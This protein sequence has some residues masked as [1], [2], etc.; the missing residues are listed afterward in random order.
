MFFVKKLKQLFRNPYF[1]TTVIVIAVFV[2]L[3]ISK[4]IYPFGE[5]SLIWGD[6]HDQV[7]AFYYHFYDCFHGNSSLLINFSTSGGI[8]F[9]G[10]LAYYLLSPV[11]FVLLLFPRENLYQAISI[12]ISIKV[13]LSALTCLYFIKTYF[14]DTPH[15]ISVLLA[16]LYAFCG[17][18]L[19]LYQITA[20]TDIV[21]LF[22]LLLIGLKKLLDLEK[23]IWY[24]VILTLCLIFCFYLSGIMLFF[25]FFSSLFYLYFFKKK[26][27]YKKAIIN[28]GIGTIIALLLSA[29]IVIPTLQE[30]MVSSRVG[31]NLTTLLNSQ[32]GPLN[33]KLC[34][35]ITAGLSI[36]GTVLLFMKGSK[37][38]KHHPV[39]GFLAC[40]ILLLLIPVFIEPVNKMWH[41]GSYAFFPLRIGFILLFI[42]L[43][44][45]LYY[46]SHIARYKEF[47][48][49]NQK[50]ALLITFVTVIILILIT[51]LNYSYLQHKIFGISLG[52]NMQVAITLLS[53][54]GLTGGSIFAILFL[55]QYNY[56]KKTFAFISVIALTNLMCS[57]YLYF[58]IDFAQKNL[59]GVYQD[60]QLM[61]QSYQENDY[62][63]VKNIY[64][65]LVMNNG[66]VTRYH[67]LDHFTSLTD[68]SN[69]ET[70]KKMGY[71]SYWVKTYSIGGSLF[72]DAVLSNQ[73]L[74]SQDSYYNPYYQYVQDY[75]DIRFY[76]NNLTIPFGYIIDHDQEIMSLANS[77][78]VQNAIYQGITGQNESIFT[79]PDESWSK[80]NLSITPDKKDK[81]LFEYE[82]LNEEKIAYLEKT[83]SV[84][85]KKNLYL[86]LLRSIDNDINKGIL[87]SVNIYINGIL[88]QE[89]Y[90][91]ETNNGLLDLGIY[92][93]EEVTIRLEFTRSIQLSVLEIGMLDLAKYEDFVTDSYLPLEIEYNENQVK[94]EVTSESEKTLFLPIAYNEGYSA[95]NNNQNV[96]VYKLYDN[97]IGIKLN[98]GINN[99]VITYTPPGFKIGIVISLITLIGTILLFKTPLYNFIINH[100]ILQNII[101]GAYLIGYAFLLIGMYLI[102]M[103][104]FLLSFIFKIRI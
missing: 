6:M 64:P 80:N 69:M 66:M 15:Y 75:G 57:S 47:P 31:F 32:F 12:L 103:L 2:V 28:L 46:F 61:E 23:P 9:L 53:M 41:L 25:I 104:C 37:I 11:S 26:S 100:K 102:P 30:I 13:L 81:T 5:N 43:L 88:Y 38:K 48:K 51:I 22:P 76:K 45:T 79:I 44:A 74:I 21:Y 86:E 50:Y 62:M 42:L 7:T 40:N 54:T 91:K 96:E 17:Y 18:Q 36:A 14:K 10:I 27:D 33:D 85:N 93:Q 16:I 84:D 65:K 1:L 59:T 24:I 95:I 71:S 101:Y 77:F 60:M 19:L 58:G 8:N 82:V 92:E 73:Y 20:W 89:K 68:K 56:D 78:A 70:L 87:E 39:L 72:S 29:F 63:R 97:F 90:P 49:K 4:G 67:T 83:I 35:F 34:F 52:K 55:N 99:I 94:I 3:F 98:S